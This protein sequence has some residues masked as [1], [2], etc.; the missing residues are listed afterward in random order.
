MIEF[1]TTALY[2]NFMIKIKGFLSFAATVNSIIVEMNLKKRRKKRAR[3]T[4]GK[5]IV[6]IYIYNATYTFSN[7]FFY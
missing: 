7:A 5:S 4:N 6:Y 2:S 1:D 3:Y